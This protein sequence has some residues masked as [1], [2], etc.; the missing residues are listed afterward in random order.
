[1]ETSSR[2]EVMQPALLKVGVSLAIVSVAGFFYA[3][4][5]TRKVTVVKDCSLE[6]PVTSLKTI[7]YDGFEDEDSFHTFPSTCM[8]LM[9]D[10]GST[11]WDCS[12]L[13]NTL[14]DLETGDGAKSEEIQVLR[15]KIGDIEKREWELENQFIRYRDLKEQESMLMELKNMLLLELARVE[16]LDRGISS[17]ETDTI[18]LKNLVEHYVG[19]L[20][21]LEDWKSENGL[22]QRKVK[23]LL[24]RTRK[25]S[26][27]IGEQNIRIEAGETAILASCDA[28]E[29][30]N[31][32]IKK[33]EDKVKELHT[34]MDQMQQEK[35]ELLRKI[36]LAE[37]SASSIS[38]IEGEGVTLET[39]NQLVNELERLKKDREAEIKE[40]I[41][42]RWSNACLRHELYKKSHPESSC[43][44]GCQ[45]IGSLL[46]HNEPCYVVESSHDEH[47]ASK[48]GKLFQ[49]IR[50]WVEGSGKAKGKVE[51]KIRH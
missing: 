32:I 34:I 43:F 14:Q 3:K 28:L 19:V 24:R 33:L 10:E 12:S 17:L 26:R 20:E 40:V 37:T 41:F 25:Q 9:E 5:M 15:S 51:E 27:V 45:E 6:T 50:R 44:E 39:Y 1:M 2:A 23:K 8:P 47:A 22:L 48:R 49:R 46:E 11:I 42:L 4:I 36:D 31:D 38:T 13:A 18:I 21:L 35:N 16:F 29:T 30:R 7:S